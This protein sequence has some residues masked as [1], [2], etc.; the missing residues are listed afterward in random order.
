MLKA[1]ADEEW[2]KHLA[3]KL[4]GI[5]VGHDFPSFPVWSPSGDI[6]SNSVV[7]L[8][9]HGGM[10]V[11]VTGSCP[12]CLDVASAFHKAQQQMTQGSCDVVI[13][14]S[15]GDPPT[16]LDSF[17][18]KD[19]DLAVYVDAQLSLF[20]E[21]GVV[22]NPTFFAIDSSGVVSHIGVGTRKPEELSV[23]MKQYCASGGTQLNSGGR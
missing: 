16:L 20:H 10:V 18:E 3:A 21:Y 2:G 12:A 14:L 22:S 8:L 7:E 17:R 6:A 15:G 13:I 1:E 19:V 5:A 23:I 9:P 4:N 11:A